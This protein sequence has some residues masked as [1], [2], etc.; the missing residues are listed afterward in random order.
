MDLHFII[1]GSKDR[2]IFNYLHDMDIYNIRASKHSIL[3]STRSI[4]SKMAHWKTLEFGRSRGCKDSGG[5]VPREQMLYFPGY[6]QE[7]D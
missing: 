7:Y 5:S 3:L 6:F 1:R 2:S 4:Y